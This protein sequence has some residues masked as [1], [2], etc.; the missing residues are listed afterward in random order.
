MIAAT[1]RLRIRP[2]SFNYDPATSPVTQIPPT[3][4][5]GFEHCLCQFLDKERHPVGA[6]DNLREHFGGEPGTA[7]QSLHQR[8]ALTFAE[9]I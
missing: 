2:S 1:Q 5:T 6:L 9:P 7:G 3:L 4:A 8:L